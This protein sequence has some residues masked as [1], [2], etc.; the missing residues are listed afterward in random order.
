MGLFKREP[1]P[2][3]DETKET[4]AQ[5]SSWTQG[6]AYLAIGSAAAFWGLVLCGPAALVV[7]ALGAGE[8]PAVAQVDVQPGLSVQQQE[9]GEYAAAYVAAWL[10]ATKDDPGELAAYIDTSQLRKITE[11]A[12][13]YR[14]LAVSSIAPADDDGLITVTV[15]ATVAEPAVSEEEQEP[16][17]VWQRRYFM[18]VIRATEGGVAAV[19]LPAPVAAPEQLTDQVTLKYPRTLATTSP[20]MTT[21][22]QFL[23]AY[24]TGNGDLSRVTSPD[25]PLRPVDPAPYAAVTVTQAAVDVDPSETPATGEQVRILATVEL[26]NVADQQLTA[27]YALTLNGRDG[28]WEVSAIDTAPVVNETSTSGSAPSTSTPA[29]LPSP[30]TTNTN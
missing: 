17:E 18:T 7:S 12:W 3:V 22:Q 16:T 2:D 1:K 6:R 13:K 21:V 25:S 10:D 28:R 8:Q 4:I 30:T 27:T 19:G 11:Q 24:L 29:P 14:D 15:A 20:A 5:G 9:A 26:V 23:L